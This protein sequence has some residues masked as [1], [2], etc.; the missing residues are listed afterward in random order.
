[1]KNF[2]I[3]SSDDYY[4]YYSEKVVRHTAQAHNW[5]YLISAYQDNLRNSLKRLGSY[6]DDWEVGHDFDDRLH[7][8]V[9]LNSL[10]IMNRKYLT[11]IDEFLTS[12]NTGGAWMVHTSI[13]IIGNQGLVDLFGNFFYFEGVLYISEEENFLLRYFA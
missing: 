7:L 12:H 11:L 5:P 13:A 2:K 1:M 8:S 3:I 4:H 9:S 10:H 6:P